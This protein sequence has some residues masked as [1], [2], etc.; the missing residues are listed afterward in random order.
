MRSDTTWIPGLVALA[1]AALLASSARADD[2]HVG[3]YLGGSLGDAAQRFEPSDY[4]LH[5]DTVGYQAALGWRP[6][7][8]VAGEVDYVNFGRARNGLNYADTDGVGAFALGFVPLLPLDLYARLG[9]INWRASISSP[10]TPFRRSGT[11]LAY[12]VGA[13]LR[14]GS[15][16]AR[17]EYS[18]YELSAASSMGLAS[19]G[20]TW[21]FF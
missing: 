11:D 1:T 15:V 8:V 16:G 5:A 17:V 9:L 4:Q 13:G 14:W 20:I 3:V 2:D 10:F 6:I 19:V 18:R 21:T 12:G 7:S